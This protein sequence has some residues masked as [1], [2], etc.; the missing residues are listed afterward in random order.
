MERFEERRA[1]IEAAGARIAAVAV[2][3]IDV[4]Q[5][6]AARLGLGY[7]I[8]ADEGGAM[9]K[10]Y[11]VWHAERK[12][13]LPAVIVVD[14]EGIVRWRRVSRSVSERPEEDEVV[15]VARRLPR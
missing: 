11:G 4:S 9:A 5:G 14:R 8:L 15:D 10:A 3:P 13:A 6:L 2:D 1:E 12:I 7:P